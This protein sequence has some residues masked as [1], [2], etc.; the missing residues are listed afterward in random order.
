MKQSQT[1]FIIQ[2]LNL[3]GFISRNFALKNFIGRLASRMDDLR[4]AGWEFETKIVKENGGKN[5]YYY[6]KSSPLK[7]TIYKVEGMDK[8]IVTYA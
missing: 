3:N 7:K 2:Q 8:E 5:F 1:N 6:V 4:K